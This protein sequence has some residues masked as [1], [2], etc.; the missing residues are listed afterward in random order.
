MSFLFLCCLLFAS[1][2]DLKS[3]IIPNFI[4]LSIFIL[5]LPNFHILGVFLALPFLV[6]AMVDPEKVGG[7]DIK[8]TAS[9]GA[10]LGWNQ[11]LIA[12]ISSL[13]AVIFL[14]LSINFLKNRGTTSSF[15]GM[16]VPLAP[17]L[18]LGVITSYFY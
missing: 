14:N 4:P 6:S 3:R 2:S 5:A 16:S 7:G 18:M 13:S 12:L 11:G 8:L 17:Y 15:T 9:I 10:F 1:I